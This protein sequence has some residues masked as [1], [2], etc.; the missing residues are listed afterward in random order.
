M[1]ETNH[2]RNDTV[3][4]EKIFMELSPGDLR[5]PERG[6]LPE[7]RVEQHPSYERYRGCHDEVGREWNWHLRP[8]INDRQTIEA[9][10]AHPH[11]QFGVFVSGGQEVGYYL[12]VS[13]DGLNVEVSDFGFYPDYRGRGYGGQALRELAENLFSS[14]VS[15]I[16]LST[17]ST[18]DPRVVDF[19]SQLGFKE[20]KR[21]SKTE[22]KSG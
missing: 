18:N 9:E 3:S 2:K 7:R 11:T 1:I 8:R 6:D 20:Y 12:L 16:W 19:Y 22:T 5:K 13:D 4:F 14:G 15:R 17:R 10:L 21:E